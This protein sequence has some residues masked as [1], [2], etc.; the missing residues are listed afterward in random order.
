MLYKLSKGVNK[1]A[2]KKDINENINESDKVF[3]KFVLS[4][5]PGHM[6]KTMKQVEEDLK[7]VDIVIEILDARIPISSQ[8]P[9]V[10]KLIKNKKKIVILNK[11]DLANENETKKWIKHFEKGKIS[12]ILCNSNNGMGTNS[13]VG[14][15]NE[16]MIEERKIAQQKGRNKIARVMIIGIPNVGK[17][18]F[19]NKV[20]SKTAMKVGNK[21]GVTKNKQWI[22]LANNIE[23]LDTPGVL[24]PKI[25]NEQIALNLA[26][27]GTI[28]SDVIDE[29][30][31]AYNLVKF[32]IEKYKDNLI[33]RYSLNP[34]I[35][36][37]ISTNA[38]LEENEKIVEIM[39][40]IG[41]K[42][43]AVAKGNDIDLDKVSRIILDDFRS[44]NL[45]R[46]TLEMAE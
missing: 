17:S 7:L 26:Y 14:K 20:S 12:A 46:I 27:T 42:R 22:R 28:K 44:G 30:E 33:G 5:Y 21:P 18:S 2:N 36:D 23:L 4:W 11:A 19:I 34:N 38:E 6:A 3:R 1:L 16:M 25:S 40:Y 13:V 24:W 39:N 29:V 45:G 9:N 37:K 35:I 43:G 31:I 41:E 15:I 10:Q 32:L 8:N